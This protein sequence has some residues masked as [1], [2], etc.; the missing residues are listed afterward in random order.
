[1]IKSQ[2]ELLSDE[3]QRKLIVFDDYNNLMISPFLESVGRS[4]DNTFLMKEYVWRLSEKDMSKLQA[5]HSGIAMWS[6][7]NYLYRNSNGTR[8]TFRVC[9]VPKA[10]GSEFAG[11]GFK[12]EQMPH[13]S[14]RGMWSAKIEEVDQYMTVHGWH[15]MAQGKNR[16]EITFDSNLV[17]TVT[18]LT[19][20][21]AMWMDAM[22]Q[23]A[24]YELM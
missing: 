1:M 15:K 21:F 17:E 24:G 6:D 12:I 16:V 4:L 18:S 10:P 7:R 14:V 19:I 22:N 8:V 13:R 23:V 11:F 20:H 2:F 9:F 3:L 5:M